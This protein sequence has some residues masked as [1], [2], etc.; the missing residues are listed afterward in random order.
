M[1][2][3]LRDIA[4]KDA[5]KAFQRA[6][7]LLLPGG[8]GDHTNIKMPNGQLITIPGQKELKTGLLMNA[9]KKAGLTTEEFAMLLKGRR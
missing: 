9:I 3:K 7:G 1:T 4:G 8:K 6:G 2:R 5:I